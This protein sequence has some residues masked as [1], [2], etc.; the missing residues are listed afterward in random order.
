MVE[1]SWASARTKDSFY[2]DFFM[3]QVTARKKNKM[4]I[5]V[6]VARKMTVAVWYILHDHTPF[7]DHRQSE[8]FEKDKK[9]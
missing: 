3:R 8:E 7:I 5:Q 6:A 4:K 9:D 1:C 2:R